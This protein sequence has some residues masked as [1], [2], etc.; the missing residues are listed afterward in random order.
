MHALK[1]WPVCHNLPQWA[2]AEKTKKANTLSLENPVW[3][4]IRESS[5]EEKQSTVNEFLKQEVSSEKWKSDGRRE[6]WID[7]KRWSGMCELSDMRQKQSE[8]T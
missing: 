8:F 7:R 3:V 4:L 2:V 6:W 1:S 5:A